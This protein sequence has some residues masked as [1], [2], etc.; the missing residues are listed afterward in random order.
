MQRQGRRMGQQEKLGLGRAVGL[1]RQDGDIMALQYARGLAALMVCLFHYEFTIAKYYGP[2]PLDLALQGGQSGVEFFF[3]LSGFIIYRAHPLRSD[4]AGRVWSFF[5]KRAIRIVPAFWLIVVPMGLVMLAVPSFGPD[6]ELTVTKL[7][8]DAF[9]I[10]RDGTMVLPPAWTLHHEC[11]FYG[12]F[13]LMLLNLRLGLAVF[14]L[15]QMGCVLAY[16][17]G[18]APENMAAA[19]LLSH[20][21]LGFAVGMATAYLHQKVDLR[22]FRAYT[23]PLACVALIGIGRNFWLEWQAHGQPAHLTLG[24]FVYYA[25]IMLWLLSLENAPRPVLDRSLGVLGYTSYALYLSHEPVQSGLLKVLVGLHL[26]HRLSPLQAY[27]ASVAVAVAASVILFYAFERPAL[28][29]L[30]RH[31]L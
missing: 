27:G 10:P 20:Y 2:Y 16:V 8:L 14:V 23:T 4:G 21:N 13:S 29:V 15:W 5:I 28:R 18:I 6:R 1:G 30:R 31:L 26:D 12:L 19:R 3:L 9:L 11:L 24:Y 22:E 7:V 25:G 17:L